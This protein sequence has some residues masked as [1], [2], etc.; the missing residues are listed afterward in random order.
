MH[1][2]HMDWDSEFLKICIPKS[3]QNV[4]LELLGHSFFVMAN[5]VV[6]EICPIFSLAIHAV[7]NRSIFSNVA[8]IFR[9]RNV[10]IR[11]Y[12][13]FLNSCARFRK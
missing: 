3:K 8:S 6:P 2:A 12:Q 11:D 10:K 7:V 5:P 9:S 1:A 13:N 4:N